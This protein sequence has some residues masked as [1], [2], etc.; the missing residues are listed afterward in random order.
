MIPQQNIPIRIPVPIVPPSVTSPQA[1]YSTIATGLHGAVGCKYILSRDQLVFVEFASGQVSAI[2]NVQTTHTY[3]V[4]ATGFNQPED[5]AV[6]ADGS[7]AWVTERVGNFTYVDLGTGA[8]RVVASG[9]VAPHQIALDEATGVA[10]VVEFASPSH[11]WRIDLGTGVRTSVMNAPDYSIGLLITDDHRYA[12]VT[13]QTPDGHGMLSKL[14]LTRRSSSTATGYWQAPL[15][16]M[17]WADPGHTSFIVP[18][19]TPENNVARISLD[20]WDTTATQILPMGSDSLPMNPSSVA[21][22]SPTLLAVCCDSQILLANLNIYTAT[23]PL[24]LGLGLIPKTYISDD[25]YATTPVGSYLQVTDAVF[26]GAVPIMVNH[27]R[28]R[29][30][31]NAQYY[32]VL[33]DGVPHTDSWTD[34][35]WDATVPGFVLK[36][37]TPVT[38]GSYAGCYPVRQAG[39][40]W[41]MANLG[42]RLDTTGLTDGAHTITVQAIQV[43]GFWWWT[44]YAVIET[45]AITAM[46]DNRRSL[47]KIDQI[48]Q[49]D[50]ATGVPVGPCGIIT[51]PPDQ[52]TFDITV[53]HPAHYLLNWNLAAWW[54]DDKS[55]AVSG[56]SYP[57]GTPAPHA[58]DFSGPAPTS[59]TPWQAAVAGDTSSTHCAHTFV[60]SAWD[61]ITDGMQWLH[62]GEYHQS[63]TILLS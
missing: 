18:Q 37:T 49:G 48:K 15:F 60:L 50:E 59:P 2:D 55:A 45:D 13:W 53:T 21:V 22:V 29:S 52:W 36:T 62:Y 30:T 41:Y 19:R 25:G 5:I 14:D 26:G 39:D 8:R 44:R 6:S 28:L 57:G 46:I 11:L 40:L 33:V 54:G 35:V 9:M 56:A 34:Y 38:L 16:F 24:L 43:S 3:R 32:Q 47:V 23:G 17:N 7:H 20:S 42:D 61:R 58:W 10:Y 51:N 63:V 12:F 1:T 27:E 4:I 31:D